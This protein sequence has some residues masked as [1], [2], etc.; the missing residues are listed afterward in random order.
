MS[1]DMNKAVAAL[2]R[3][4]DGKK[5]PPQRTP[6][7]PLERDLH[8]TWQALSSPTAPKR[9]PPPPAGAERK[10]HFERP[11]W[12]EL[13][14]MGASVIGAGI[15]DNLGLDMAPEFYA[16]YLAGK[17]QPKVVDLKRVRTLPFIKKGEEINN[18]RFENDIA[19]F[20]KGLGRAFKR[21]LKAGKDDFTDRYN[22]D[23][24]LN[25]KNWNRESL[26]NPDQFLATGRSKLR[27]ELKGTIT[28]TGDA[29]VFRGATDHVWGDR[30]DF[31]KGSLL[32][33]ALFFPQQRLEDLG[34]AQHYLYGSGWR[35]AVTIYVP[36]LNG[37]MGEPVVT[38][39]KPHSLG[40]EDTI[41]GIKGL[42]KSGVEN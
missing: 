7:H 33:K 34:R 22:V 27:S 23:F 4:L 2:L 6:E 28:N 40:Y 36:L 42:L 14:L 19:D 38:Y 25:P 3:M 8:E 29:L 5:E 26:P 16:H 37:R 30:Y 39:G 32:N 18:K 24:G 15:A 12:F 35:R 13:E 31:N 41:D 21:A 10:V 9:K 1:F 11:K 17:G 20:G